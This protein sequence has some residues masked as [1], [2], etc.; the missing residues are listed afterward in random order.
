M[1]KADLHS[2][3]AAAR[4]EHGW[5]QAD[6]A[7]RARVSRAEVSAI[8]TGRLVP[9]T[10]AALR[11]AGALG[12]PVERVFQLT[13]PGARL[14]WAWPAGTG[15]HRAWEAVV[16]DRRVLYPSEATAAGTLPH[17]RRVVRGS[18][19]RLP[20]ATPPERTLVIAGCDPTVGLLTAEVAAGS[21]VRVLPLTRSS[22]EALDLLRRGLVHVAGLHLGDES[23]RSLNEDAVRRRLGGGYRLLHLVR[24]EEGVAVGPGRARSVEG[25][26]RGRTRWV[27]REE[28]SGARRCLDRLLGSRRRPPGYEH[29]APDHRALAGTISSGWA[30]AGICVRAVAVEARLDFLPVQR[31]AYDLCFAEALMDDPRIDALLAAAR[32]ASYRRLLRDVP[33]W[34]VTRTGDVRAVA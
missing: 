13:S 25:L 33:G 12:V 27:N 8:E 21:G 5:S 16:G 4:R 29:V 2:S 1:S 23:G 24:W 6:L 10:V 3:L 18:P 34:D 14:N 20:G 9:S 32:S 19:E 17:D 15:D 30:E 7:R 26:L 28:G 31:E 11:L 22:G